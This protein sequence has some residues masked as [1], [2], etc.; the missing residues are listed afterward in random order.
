M[1]RKKLF[2]RRQQLKHVQPWLQVEKFELRKIRWVHSKYPPIVT[3]AVRQL[4]HSSISISVK[5][6]CREVSFEVLEFSNKRQQKQTKNFKKN[7]TFKNKKAL[8]KTYS[9]FRFRVV[10]SD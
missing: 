7:K 8:T 3:M 4:A 5:I 1:A 10:W 9:H 2:H 6:Q